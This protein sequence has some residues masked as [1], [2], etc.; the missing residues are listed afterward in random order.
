[1]TTPKLTAH[2]GDDYTVMMLPGE[3]TDDASFSVYGT[4][5]RELAEIACARW[6]SAP[7]MREAL[8]AIL[9]ELPHYIHPWP[10]LESSDIG[11]AVALAVATLA[12]AKEGA[13]S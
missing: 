11:K 1:M 9:H 10:P 2:S 12:L 13:T 4:E 6:N 7:A 8:E 3:G 5:Q